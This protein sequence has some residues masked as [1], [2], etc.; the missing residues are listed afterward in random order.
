V[1]S[2]ELDAELSFER[3]DGHGDT[4]RRQVEGAGSSR[5]TAV[6]GDRD[7][8]TKLTKFHESSSQHAAAQIRRAAVQPSGSYLR[9]TRP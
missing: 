4:R 7:E 8:C 2:E 9:R 1:S 5:D 6:L 3:R